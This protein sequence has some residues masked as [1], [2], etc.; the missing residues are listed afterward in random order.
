MFQQKAKYGVELNHLNILSDTTNIEF[1]GKVKVS[2]STN[3]L[4]VQKLFDV[5]KKVVGKVTGA[6]FYSAYSYSKTDSTISVCFN[7]YYSQDLQFIYKNTLGNSDKVYVFGDLSSANTAH[8]KVND[9]KTE[10]P[11]GTYHVTDLKKELKLKLNK[12]S[13]TGETRTYRWKRETGSKFLTFSNFGLSLDPVMSGIS[14]NTGRFYEMDPKYGLFL[15]S[16]FKEIN[17]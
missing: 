7:L 10:L 17:N 15:V 11:F 13:L 12:G 14:I 6:N 1:M 2:Y 3:K 16:L 4:D 5:F 8:C 9:L